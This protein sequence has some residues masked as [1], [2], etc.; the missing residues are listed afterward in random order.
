MSEHQEIKLSLQVARRAVKIVVFIGMFAI[1]LMMI[2]IYILL[3]QITATAQMSKEIHSMQE[4]IKALEA[5]FE[6]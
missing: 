2:N 4:Q 6:K 1:F 5:K 3:S